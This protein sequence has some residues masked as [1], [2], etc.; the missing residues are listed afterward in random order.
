MMDRHV[1]KMD[2]VRFRPDGRAKYLSAGTALSM[3]AG[4]ISI[5]A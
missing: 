2:H 3:A 4:I 5:P 1:A